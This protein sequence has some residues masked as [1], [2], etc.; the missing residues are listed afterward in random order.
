M[1]FVDANIFLEVALDD[2][3]SKECKTLFSH[4]HKGQVQGITSDFIVYTCL[5]Q[6]ESKTQSVENMQK[7]LVFLNSLEGMKIDSPRFETLYAALTIM[8]K[9]GMDFDDALVVAIMISSGVEELVSFDKDFDN[10]KG[11]KRIEPRN[12]D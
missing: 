8:P 9:Y 5:L 1:I 12:V 4:I 6:I 3:R 2:V 7:F 10:V 11:I